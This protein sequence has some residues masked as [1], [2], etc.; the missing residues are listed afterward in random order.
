MKPFL[1]QTMSVEMVSATSVPTSHPMLWLQI[2]VST[3]FPL[4]VGFPTSFAP[5]PAPCSWAIVC[6]WLKLNATLSDSPT[7]N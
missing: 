7:V 2:L 3:L 5:K 1:Y 4:P 6:L